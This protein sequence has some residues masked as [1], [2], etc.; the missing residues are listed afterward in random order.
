MV[1]I[2]SLAAASL[3][4]P[5]IVFA[6]MASRQ[7]LQ[8][9]YAL[10][11]LSTQCKNLRERRELACTSWQE[12]KAEELKRRQQQPAQQNA[13]LA[14]PSDQLLHAGSGSGGGDDSLRLVTSTDMFESTYDAMLLPRSIIVTLGT[15]TA[16][17]MHGALTAV[18]LGILVATGIEPESN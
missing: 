4:I 7:D 10:H 1:I 3:V 11:D 14:S 2:F 12:S 13:E 8:A 17:T 5:I 18:R 9:A 6:F 15:C 16:A